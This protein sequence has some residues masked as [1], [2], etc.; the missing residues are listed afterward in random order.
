MKFERKWLEVLGIAI[1]FPSAIIV[2]AY[3]FH[4]L[5]E[6]KILS[7]M[8]GWGLFVFILLAFVGI[9]IKDAFSPKK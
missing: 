5:I 2:T 7:P 1:S 4:L 8:V 3:G 9:L 6:E